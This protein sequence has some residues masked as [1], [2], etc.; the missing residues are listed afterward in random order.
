MHAYEKNFK[1]LEDCCKKI[2]EARDDIEKITYQYEG[3]FKEMMEEEKPAIA[4][5]VEDLRK[6]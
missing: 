4:A 3:Y 6:K 5:F 1:M 2:E